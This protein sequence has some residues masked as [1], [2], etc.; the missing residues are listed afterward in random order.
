[1]TPGVEQCVLDQAE[2]VV[3]LIVVCVLCF[4]KYY[5]LTAY[6]RA[7]AVKASQQRAGGK[8]DALFD[9]RADEEALRR[10]KIEERRQQQQDRLNT[11]YNIL[12]HT[13]MAK[14]MRE[15]VGVSFHP[16]YLCTC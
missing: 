2:L 15:Q 4:R 7:E 5:D 3:L 10:Q 1:M 12:K 13:D 6:E 11:A 14:D 16:T 8:S 9:A